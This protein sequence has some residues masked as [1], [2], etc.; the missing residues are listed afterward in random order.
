MLTKYFLPNKFRPFGFGLLIAVLVIFLLNQIFKVEY[1]WLK[2]DVFAIV[3][4][5][6]F[7][8]EFF[9]T[10]KQNLIYPITLIFAILGITLLATT[11]EKEEKPNYNE[12]RAESILLTFHILLGI[13]VFSFI[14]IY[15]L[16][17]LYFF[18]VMTFLPQTLYFVIFQAKRR[19]L[20][21]QQ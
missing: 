16:G 14:F 2:A 7:G 9:T 1:S 5:G 4:G 15:D 10:V 21:K 20:D 3:T 12:L 18:V 6:F 11:K 8:F 17:L 19:K 13:A